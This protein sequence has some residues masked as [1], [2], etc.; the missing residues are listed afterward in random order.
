MWFHK[1]PNPADT[2]EMRALKAATKK[3][4]LDVKKAS[5]KVN[6]QLQENGFTFLIF[7]AMSGHKGGSK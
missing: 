5:D 6:K 7:A 4:T 2:P 3:Q 1:K